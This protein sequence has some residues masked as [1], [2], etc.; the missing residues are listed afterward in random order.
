MECYG[1]PEAIITDG[2][3]VFRAIQSRAVYEALGIHKEEIERRQPWQSYIET[4]FNVQRR[5][6]DFHFAEAESWSELVRAHDRWVEDHNEQRHWAHQN[7]E[8]GRRSPR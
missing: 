7:R 4:T 8:N 5:M 6:A 2:G 3:G 1:S